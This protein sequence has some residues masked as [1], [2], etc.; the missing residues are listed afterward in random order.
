MSEPEVRETEVRECPCPFC[1]GHLDD[2]EHV[3]G[4]SAATSEER[5]A[6]KAAAL[7]AKPCP[8]CGLNELELSFDC[9]DVVCI[10]RGCLATG[11]TCEADLEP[12]AFEL[13]GEVDGKPKPCPFCG[14]R[15]FHLD[16]ELPGL[17]CDGCDAKGPDLQDA[18]EALLWERWNQ[19]A[20]VAG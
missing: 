18:F 5:A 7:A 11:P 2:E 6:D 20:E 16:K 12:R 15:A 17:V 13:W 19:R 4:M 10:N 8:F 14:G 1:G 3:S 9:W